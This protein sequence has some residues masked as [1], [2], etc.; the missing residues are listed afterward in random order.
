M[1]GDVLKRHGKTWQLLGE[2]RERHPEIEAAYQTAKR[3]L[4]SQLAD[5]AIADLDPAQLEQLSDPKLAS[6]AASLARERATQRRWLAE[7]HGRAEYG[8]AVTHTHDVTV[9]AVVALPA[10]APL[11]PPATVAGTAMAPQLTAGHSHDDAQVVDV[12]V[13]SDSNSRDSAAD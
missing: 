3:A 1:V 13:I 6:A 12:E 4:A 9:R 7:R 10:L 2:M 11:D 8:E 5:S